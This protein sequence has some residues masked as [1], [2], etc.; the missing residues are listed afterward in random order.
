ME[1]IMVKHPVTPGLTLWKKKSYAMK[2]LQKY[3][4]SKIIGY[5]LHG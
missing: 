3:S 2:S 4:T 5:T 1:I